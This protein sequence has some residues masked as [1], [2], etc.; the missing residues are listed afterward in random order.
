[1]RGCDRLIKVLDGGGREWAG[2]YV[3]GWGGGRGMR[4]RRPVRIKF[5][6]LLLQSAAH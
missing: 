2:G 3:R 1:M 6:N 4:A 5:K